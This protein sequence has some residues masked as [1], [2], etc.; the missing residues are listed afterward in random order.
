MAAS[1]A[2]MSVVLHELGRRTVPLPLVSS[3]VL[4]PTALLAGDNRAPAAELLPALPPGTRAPQWSWE[5]QR[6]NRIR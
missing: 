3:A 2:E 1:L 5:A 6:D 4:A